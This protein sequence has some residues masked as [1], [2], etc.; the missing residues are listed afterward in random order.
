MLYGNRFV[1]GA[2]DVDILIARLPP[3]ARRR[4]SP[5]SQH[6]LT[7]AHRQPSHASLLAC[8]AVHQEAALHVRRRELKRVASGMPHASRGCSIS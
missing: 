5:G 4:R 1:R 7:L 8:R 2:Y 6:K 3:R